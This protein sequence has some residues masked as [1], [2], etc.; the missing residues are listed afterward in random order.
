[1]HVVLL[2]D[3]EQEIT[4]KNPHGTVQAGATRTAVEEALKEL[5]HRVTVVPASAELVAELRRLA[6]DFVFN[7]ATGLENKGQQANIVGLLELAGYPFL[8][9][10]MWTH[11]L[12]LH[13]PIA[14]MV[15]EKA[16]LPTPP[17]Q[18]FTTGDEPVAQALRYPLIVKPAHEGSSIGISAEGVVDH[19][20]GLRGAVRRVITE[21]RQP[22]LVEEFISGREFTVGIL[23]SRQP[24]VLPIEEIIFDTPGGGMY[25][26]DVK[27][28]DAVKPVCPAD[29]PEESAEEIRRICLGAFRAIGCLDLARI[30]IRTDAEERPF[31]LE[32]NTLPGLQPDYSEFPRMALAAGIS[33]RDLVDQLMTSA[34]ERRIFDETS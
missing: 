27:S 25:T 9:S 1:M 24:M 15:F 18:V 8:G 4:G 19:E 26:Y 5:G 13:K 29:L 34:L 14:K 6:P 16:G 21:L 28:R 7:I 32:I 30:D 31:I 11:V 17:F 12:G 22:A 10:E 20:D 23:G 2:I 3:R 33:F